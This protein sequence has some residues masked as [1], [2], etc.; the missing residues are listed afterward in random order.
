[1]TQT[2][3]YLHGKRKVYVRSSH[4]EPYGMR[5]LIFVIKL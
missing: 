5:A 2:N 1:M 4:D 3:T